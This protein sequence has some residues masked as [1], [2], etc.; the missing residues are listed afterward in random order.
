MSYKTALKIGLAAVACYLPF[1]GNAQ[2]NAIKEHRIGKAYGITA[3]QLAEMI[4][5]QSFTIYVNE[6]PIAIPTRDFFQRILETNVVDAVGEKDYNELLH[7]LRLPTG[8]VHEEKG[9]D[10]NPTRYYSETGG[11]NEYEGLNL[12]SGI[13]SGDITQRVRT[14]T[15]DIT[16][17]KSDGY[18]DLTRTRA[19]EALMELADRVFPPEV[20]ASHNQGKEIFTDRFEVR[21]LGRVIKKTLDSYLPQ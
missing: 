5:R 4:G 20:R 9:I 7:P 15:K 3:E 17:S 18:I 16:S 2:A 19:D 14:H 11:G 6:K 1:A 10:N 8:V 13:L 21:F 12:F